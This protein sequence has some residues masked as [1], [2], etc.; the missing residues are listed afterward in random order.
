MS[1]ERLK[2]RE[3]KTYQVHVMSVAEPAV[4]REAALATEFTMMSKYAGSF[5]AVSPCRTGDG[6]CLVLQ[7]KHFARAETLAV[8]VVAVLASS[9]GSGK[10]I[11]VAALA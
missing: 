3:E 6:T 9:A 4:V 5:S 7:D 8:V 11:A 1:A 10:V 2:M